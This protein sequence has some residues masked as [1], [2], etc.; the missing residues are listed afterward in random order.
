MSV[1]VN[2]SRGSRIPFAPKQCNLKA[3]RIILV[4][5]NAPAN[6]VECALHRAA[7]ARLRGLLFGMETARINMHK[8][9]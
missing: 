7:A 2:Y 1:R 4:Q 6:K 8:S 5:I 9:T 3:T